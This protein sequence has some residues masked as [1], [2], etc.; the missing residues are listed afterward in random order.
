MAM[1]WFTEKIAQLVLKNYKQ[2]FLAWLQNRGLHIPKK[3]KEQLAQKY[4][5][6]TELIEEIEKFLVNKIIERL[7]KILQ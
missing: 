5:I 2:E 1:N 6:P 4:Q 7:S 3:T